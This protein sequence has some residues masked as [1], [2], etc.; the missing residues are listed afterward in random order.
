MGG[1]T[2]R[3]SPRFSQLARTKAG[4]VVGSRRT[5]PQADGHSAPEAR[6]SAIAVSTS[7]PDVCMHPVVRILLSRVSEQI[8]EH[9]TLQRAANLVGYNPTYVC[10]LFRQETGVNFHEWIEARRIERS[11]RLLAETRKLVSDIAVEVGYRDSAFGRAFKRC[12]GVSP[13]TFRARHRRRVD[14]AVMNAAH[15]PEDSKAPAYLLL[16]GITSPPLV[17]DLVGRQGDRPI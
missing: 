14:A 12:T 15:T 16:R 17:H 13:Q 11:A 5:Q 2:Q 4:R 1:K 3:A 6:H 7:R 8:A 10:W 9:W